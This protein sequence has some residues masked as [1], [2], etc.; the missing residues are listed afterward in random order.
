MSS[1][2]A[3]STVAFC[4][5]VVRRVEQELDRGEFEIFE[6]YAEGALLFT[7]VALFS[8]IFPM[9]AVCALVN[10]CIEMRTDTFRMVTQCARPTRAGVARVGPPCAPAGL[11]AP[12]SNRNAGTGE[13]CPVPPTTSGPGSTFFASR[14]QSSCCLR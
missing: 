12:H 13:S 9:A 1:T 3:A 5:A 6:D 2:L 14:R 10:N 8:V 11:T 4:A 7:M